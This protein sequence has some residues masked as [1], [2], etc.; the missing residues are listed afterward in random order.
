MLALQWLERVEEA[1]AALGYKEAQQAREV[2]PVTPKPFIALSGESG[3]GKTWSLC[4][5]ALTEARHGRITMLVRAPASLEAL[6]QQVIEQACQLDLALASS[7]DDLVEKLQPKVCDSDGCWL[8]LCID[9][10]QDRNF[11][12]AIGEYPWFALGVRIRLSCQ[13][14]ITAELQQ[15]ANVEVAHVRDF[16][17][18]ELR[19]FL[20]LHGQ[21]QPLETMPDDVFELLLKPI[22]AQIFIGLPVR[23]DWTG[24][25]EYELFRRYWQYATEEYRGQSEH[26][27]D[28]SALTRLSG[29]LASSRPCYPFPRSELEAA[30]LDQERVQRLEE[31]GLVRWDD[32][33]CLRFTTDRMLNWAVAEWIVAEALKRHWTPQQ[34]IAE[35]A[36]LDELRKADGTPFGSRL[37][38]VFMDVMWLASKRMPP[39]VVAEA[40]LTKARSDARYWRNKA[41]W[42][43]QVAT[44]GSSVL[45]ALEQLA[46][47]S[48][49]PG[50]ADLRGNVIAAMAAIGAAERAWV[51]AS[52][53]M[54][55]STTNQSARRVAVGVAGDVPCD[56]AIEP[57]WLIHLERTREYKLFEQGEGAN[58]RRSTLI[59]AKEASFDAAKRAL[60]S[61]AWLKSKIEITQDALALEQLLWLLI[62]DSRLSLD[63]RKG[64]YLRSREH[65]HDSL[66]SNCVALV[67]AVYVFRDVDLIDWLDVVPDDPQTRARDRVLRG[68]SIL[69]PQSALKEIASSLDSHGWFASEW[70]MH[71]IARSAGVRPLADAIESRVAGGEDPLTD[72]VL[73]YRSSPELLD[74][75]S[76]ERI[77]DAFAS[78]LADHN[79][80]QEK[81]LG[82]ELQLGRLHHLFE[83]V[84]RLPLLWQTELVARRAG[85]ALEKELLRYCRNRTGRVGRVR[86]RDG[87]QCER[88]LAMI[89]GSG[90]DELV[91]SELNR[92]SPY[93]QE[94]GFHSAFWSA[95]RAV[96]LRLSEMPLGEE[97]ADGYRSVISMEAYAVHSCDGQ[98]EAMIRAGAPVYV[99]AAEIRSGSDRLVDALRKR[100]TE[101]LASVSA[102]DHKVAADLVGFLRDETDASLL[103]PMFLDTSTSMSLRETMIGS[104]NAL[105]FYDPAALPMARAILESSPDR[106]AHFTAFYLARLGD[107]EAR[108]SVCSWI[109]GRSL[110]HGSASDQS[111][112][113]ELA[114]HEDSRGAVVQ[115]LLH[116]RERGHLIWEPW[117]ATLLAE[118][119]DEDSTEQLLRRAH[120]AS[121]VSPAH[122]AAAI[123]YLAKSSSDEAYFMAKR[124]WAMERTPVA[125]DL[126]LDID[127]DRALTYLLSRFRDEKPSLRAEIARRLRASI[128]AD[129]MQSRLSKLVA[130]NAIDDRLVGTEL[131]GW[132][133]PSMALDW[134]DGLA[135]DEDTKLRTLALEATERRTREQAALD[136]LAEMSS[137]TKP[138]KWARLNIVLELVDPYPV[139]HRDDPISLGPFL[140]G[141]PPEFAIEAK[142]LRDKRVKKVIDEL[143]RADSKFAS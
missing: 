134:L 36:A 114:E 47:Q 24:A 62:A 131:A 28:R 127:R 96:A 48:F 90:F 71:D 31:V 121:Q 84:G 80:A 20:Q 53:H 142:Q 55:A 99:N 3:Q 95:D 67:D 143:K 136:H 118:H 8:T 83:V 60:A 111:Y 63:A 123:Q 97:S 130:S 61:D 33:D 76:I 122:R 105:D 22:H 77:M 88:M 50:E 73:H 64:I 70:W 44:L 49:A 79:E 54:L 86:D 91:L 37:G 116:S 103:L 125:I 69:D 110:G 104:F 117:Q 16:S 25:T 6:L 18:A 108:K 46:L 1:A 52:V 30:E 12:Q 11:A 141:E 45:P 7:F 119:G 19:R 100:I 89:G 109:L 133:P 128:P 101:L 68:L 26:P 135:S 42:S 10:V 15:H 112:L 43:N 106:E 27:F 138:Q 5:L 35:L 94:D 29:R 2:P 39:T 72:F 56:E 4:Q 66:P 129:E 82:E 59:R 21:E 58:E 115:F 87:E 57:L 92:T 140:E 9:D 78:R 132:M 13:P 137:S 126:L 139:W 41:A 75:R 85:T 81:S 17:S 65:L 23:S 102:E 93:G 124:M 51:A 120:R 14:R 107:A 40:L 74:E 32:N 34:L 98:L 38:Y 113:L